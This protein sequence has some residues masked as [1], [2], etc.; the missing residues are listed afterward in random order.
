[1]R[2]RHLGRSGLQVSVIALGSW[3]TYG[4]QVD[5]ARSTATIRRAL[6]LGI[7]FFDTADVYHRGAAETEL[8]IALEGINRS[9]YVLASKCY[10]PMSN[11]PND[12]GLS[13]KHIL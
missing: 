4:N 1:M 6:D 5:R 7:V 2:Y 10:W 3:L 8:G 12:R 13:R 9:D 11:N